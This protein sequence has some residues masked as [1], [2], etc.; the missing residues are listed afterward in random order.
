MN[1]NMIRINYFVTQGSLYFKCAPKKKCELL[2]LDCETLTIRGI[3]VLEGRD[4]MSSVMFS[5][6]ESLGMI[7]A[8]KYVRIKS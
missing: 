8:G 5:D 7:T 2:I 3:A 1:E 4:W 6:G